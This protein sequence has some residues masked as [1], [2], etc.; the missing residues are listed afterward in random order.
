MSSSER[1]VLVDVPGIGTVYNELPEV[2]SRKGLDVASLARA[3][4]LDFKTVQRV[5][6]NEF[7][8][9][10]FETLVSILAALD[11]SFEKVF[12]FERDP[13]YFNPYVQDNSDNGDL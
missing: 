2:A 5:W 1:Q 4:Y 10:T 9:L 12:P 6:K 7:K 3:A 11:E 13:R 8:G